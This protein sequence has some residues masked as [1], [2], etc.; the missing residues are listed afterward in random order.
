MSK[1]TI[2]NGTY[3]EVSPDS[4]SFQN[5]KQIQF[6]YI[7]ILIASSFFLIVGLTVLY[8][9]FMAFFKEDNIAGILLAY[10]WL[11]RISL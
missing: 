11:F 5:D 7:F 8:F 2:C 9:V 10:F 4:I 6:R 1:I 3:M